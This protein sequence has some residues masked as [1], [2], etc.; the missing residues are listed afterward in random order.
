MSGYAWVD[1]WAV[2]LKV[3]VLLLCKGLNMHLCAV[4]P[5]VADGVGG[6]FGGVQSCE[7]A[8]LYDLEGT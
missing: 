5:M 4:V 6:H 7:T 2:I 8:G 1:F 3:P